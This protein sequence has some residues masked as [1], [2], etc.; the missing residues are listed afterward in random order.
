[1]PT[2]RVAGRTDVYLG[3]SWQA[4]MAI[5]CTS[6]ALGVVMM[7]WPGR[8]VQMS[9]LLFGIALLLTAAWQLVLAFRGRI[10]TGLKVVEF[11]T[12]LIAILLA[13][14]CMRS[15]DWVSLVALWV[16][17]GWVIRGI[18]QATVAVWSD[19][20]PGTGRQEVA[21]LLTLL[22]GIAVVIW[23]IDTLD[24]LA[25]LAGVFL[26]LLGVSEIRIATRIARP[27]ATPEHVGVQGLLRSQS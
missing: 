2:F 5:G 13:L 7:V 11:V 3:E 12:A 25:V 27:D 1:M 16:G 9:E 20:L 4:A 23:P 8:S 14:W 19:Q 6:V 24:A 10:R 15:G 17:L 22:A 18:V 21:G 26:I